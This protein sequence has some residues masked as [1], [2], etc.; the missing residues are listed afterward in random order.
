ML[1]DVNRAPSEALRLL[2]KML[3]LCVVCLFLINHEAFRHILKNLFC[4]S[5]IFVGETEVHT[6]QAYVDPY[7]LK[8]I[9]RVL[10][11]LCIPLQGETCLNSKFVYYF[12]LYLTRELTS[13]Y[14][15]HLKKLN[16]ANNS[17]NFWGFVSELLSSQIYVR[18]LLVT[19]DGQSQFSQL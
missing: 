14:Y 1:S 11:H 17:I 18:E 12:E 19:N 16:N 2:W 3:L 6:G 10:C 8:S 5:F 15:C 4:I 13:V 9:F 7:I